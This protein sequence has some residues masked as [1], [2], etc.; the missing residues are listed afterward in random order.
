MSNLNYATPAL[1]LAAMGNTIYQILQ[2]TTPNPTITD[3]VNNAVLNAACDSANQQF[4]N[5]LRGKYAV[6]V[7]SNNG[8]IIRHAIRMVIYM[9]KCDARMEVLRPEDRLNYE[10]GM[11]YIKA[12]QNNKVTF[13]FPDTNRTEKL[14]GP[15]IFDMGSAI[16]AADRTA[17]SGQSWWDNF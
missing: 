12:I 4:D 16:A 10:D 3:I 14:A 13:D 17:V 7:T 1:V 5:A 15:G 11:N 2:I 9:V 6:P 8:D